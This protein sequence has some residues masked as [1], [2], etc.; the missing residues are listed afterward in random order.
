MNTGIAM[1]SNL[2]EI[3]IMKLFQVADRYCKESNWKTLALLKIC[4]FSIGVMIGILLP[5][6]KKKA[7][8]GIGAVAFLATY[9]PL[10]GKFFR[11]WQQEKQEKFRSSPC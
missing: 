3:Q 10:M 11:T 4:L 7:A 5:K 8:L 9:L 2:K 1:I 6:E